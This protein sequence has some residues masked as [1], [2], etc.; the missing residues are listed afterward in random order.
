M[1]HKND[2]RELINLDLINRFV[3]REFTELNTSRNIL[4]T[5]NIDSV[6]SYPLYLL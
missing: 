2:R 1:S 4:Y 6:K 5:I 3:A